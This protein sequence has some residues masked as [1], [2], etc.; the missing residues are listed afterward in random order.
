MGF[1]INHN[2][3]AQNV[4]RNLGSHYS[5]LAESV[6]RLSTGLRINSA[7]DD[8]S[9]L[10]IRELMR[11]DVSALHQGARNAN[12]AISMIQVADGSLSVI[13]EKLIRLKELAEQAATGTYD[14]TQRLM[15]ESEYQEMAKE[16]TRIANSTDFNG[17]KLLDGSLAGRHD[18][19]G[20][21]SKGQMKI[22]FGTGNSSAED[23][24]Y[25]EIGDCTAAALG[26]GN[27]AD[28]PYHDYTKHEALVTENQTF[29]PAPSY[30]KYTDPVTGRIYYSEG[31][32]FFSDLSDPAN[33]ALDW[34]KDR[35]VIDRLNQHQISTQKNVPYYA[36]RHPDG[37][38]FYTRD[39]MNFTLDPNNPKAEV[40]NYQNYEHRKV[41]SQLTSTSQSMIV[42]TKWQQY[43]DPA[44]QP[45]WS[46]DNGHT[47]FPELKEPL[48]TEGMLDWN[49][50]DHK[51]KIIGLKPALEMTEVRGPVKPYNY[52]S[53]QFRPP[54]TSPLLY[55]V[56]DP[57]KPA[58]P[59]YTTSLEDPEKYMV[60]ITDENALEFYPQKDDLKMD[61]VIKFKGPRWI[62]LPES[63]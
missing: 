30:A 14:S 8:A 9:G 51:E 20:L 49:N 41:I 3:M 15:L 52:G 4:S 12:D 59:F 29:K 24:Y 45:W 27:T 17:I 26:V 63:G 58:E 42:E 11:A 5:S 19:S 38:I 61:K 39:N 56:T 34:T 53:P 46:C 23:Y 33:S 37:R 1:A 32:Y 44:G 31:D 10:A 22:H 18:G 28:R 16:I 7:A 21:V 54:N 55:K 43:N 60:S 35:E 47:F 36:M 57:E 62:L 13:D 2:L 6:Q 48:T 25:V 40:L 50:P